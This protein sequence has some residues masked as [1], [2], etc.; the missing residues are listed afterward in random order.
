MAKKDAT[1]DKKKPAYRNLSE[2][3]KTL[4]AEGAVALVIGVIIV[5]TPQLSGKVV[6]YMLGGFL[7]VYAILSFF[8][9][10]SAKQ[11]EEPSTWLIARG[12]IALAGG[13]IIMFWPGL[14]KLTLLYILAIFAITAGVII[15][16]TGLL[17]KWDSI[18]KWFSAIAGI[19]SIAFGLVLLGN[20]GNLTD[21]IIWVSGLYAMIFGMLVMFLGVGARGISKASG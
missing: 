1:A 20:K 18:Y 3:W 19:A 2:N 12:V 4:I 13:L 14:T 15:G 7:I 11:I 17:Q 21:P 9:A 10:R 8:S 6:K 16:F 5:A